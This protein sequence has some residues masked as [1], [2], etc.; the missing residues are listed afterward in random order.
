[1]RLAES[2][3]HEIQ[4]QILGSAGHIFPVPG[5]Y[6]DLSGELQLTWKLSLHTGGKVGWLQ[7][8]PPPLCEE[9]YL[10]ELE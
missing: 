5:E 9:H 8:F 10:G 2:L 1:M 4:C 7:G 3:L 6:P